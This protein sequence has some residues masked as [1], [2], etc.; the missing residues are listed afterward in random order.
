MVSTIVRIG[1]LVRGSKLTES[2]PSLL[3]SG[4]VIWLGNAVIFGLLY[5]ELDSGTH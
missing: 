1:H 2:A 3:A 4:A 5:W